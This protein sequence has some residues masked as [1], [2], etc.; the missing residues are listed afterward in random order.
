MRKVQPIGPTSVG[1]DS[2]PETDS[3]AFG[4]G[5]SSEHCLFCPLA[6]QSLDDNLTHMSSVH[7]FFIPDAEYLVNI[8]G[9]IAYL[10]EKIAVGNVC[11]YCSEKS[12][13]FRTL[14]AVLKHMID[15]SHCKIAYDTED[16]RLEVSD[17]YDFS[18]SYPDTHSNEEEWEDV[19]DDEPVDD[20]S[21]KD[22]HVPEGQLPNEE[23]EELPGSQI[24]YGDS[25]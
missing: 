19:E 10:G 20:L 23:E 1:K 3:H 24:T 16:D 2:T 14:E 15:K 25:H 21:N 17:F 22:D 8:T 12:R 11:I 9:L 18:S 6:S 4:D 13:D 5:D 7:S